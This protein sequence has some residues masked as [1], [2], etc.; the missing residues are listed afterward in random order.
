MYINDINNQTNNQHDNIGEGKK[1]YVI[2]NLLTEE[3]DGKIYYANNDREAE[4]YFAIEMDR[5]KEN[6]KY[7]KEEHFKLVCI[8]FLNFKTC[9]IKNNK[10]YY[11]YR[12]DEIKDF[13]KSPDEKKYYNNISQSNK[14]NEMQDIYQNNLNDLKEIK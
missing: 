6:N 1:M 4:Y 9:I 2:Y 8:G 5:A 7:F 10:E 12:F 14:H 11:P 13:F 3:I